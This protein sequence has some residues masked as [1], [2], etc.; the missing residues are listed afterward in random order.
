MSESVFDWNPYTKGYEK[1]HALISDEFA[2]R[3]LTAPAN[4]IDL[5][6]K[7]PTFKEM[8]NAADF[9]GV[10]LSMGGFVGDPYSPDSNNRDT[11]LT[12]T[13]RLEVSEESMHVCRTNDM[14][15]ATLVALTKAGPRLGLAGPQ[16]GQVVD[17]W[18]ITDGRDHMVH[19]SGRA[20]MTVLGVTL[21]F[22]LP[23]GWIQ[24]L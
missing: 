19:P 7:H 20:M 1:L 14:K 3:E 8:M 6:D 16:G 18:R 10:V 22:R 2:T 4:I 11:T 24:Q 15:L 23:T 9:P 17:F 5:T 13:Y 21:Q 12:Q